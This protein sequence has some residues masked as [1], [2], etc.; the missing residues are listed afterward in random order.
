MS[1]SKAFGVWLCCEAPCGSEDSVLGG[2]EG[3]VDSKEERR[4][5]GLEIVYLVVILVCTIGLGQTILM[6]NGD[7]GRTVVGRAEMRRVDCSRYDWA[8]TR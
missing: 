6:E 2:G 7:E 1:V 4:G 8:V 3:A 5:L